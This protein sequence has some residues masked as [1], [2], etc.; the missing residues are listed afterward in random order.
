MDYGWAQEY[1]D[2]REKVRA[3]VDEHDSPEIHLEY[4]QED[5][6]GPR[7]AA[8]R[9]ALDGRGWLRM[10]WP[11]EYGGEGK[12]P[13]YQFILIE[14]L[15]YRAM[16]YGLLSVTSV[17]PAIMAYGSDEQKKR[18]MPGIWDGSVSFAIGYTEPEAGTDLASLQ[19]RAV[20]DGDDWVIN[21]QKIFTSGAHSATH[22][23]LAARTD[24]DAPKHRGIS[25]FIVPIDAPGVTITPM[26]T[27][28]GL[29]T[30]QTFYDDVRVSS[31]ALVGEENRGWYIVAHALNHERVGLAPTG[32]LGRSFDALVQ[33]LRE[34]RPEALEDPQVRMRLAEMRMEVHV[35][36]ALATTNGSIIANGGTPTME[37][38]MAKVW[39]SELRHRLH[40]LAMDLLGRY[41][42]LTRESGDLAP[43]NGRLEM[44]Y[45]TSPI[46]R[47][48]GG[49]NEIQR[50]IIAQRGLGLPR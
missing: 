39:S 9:K 44:I 20:R 17:A 23:W 49:T 38:S 48:G 32:G 4:S 18:Y 34:R 24:S 29:R 8:F 43:A 25:M 42:G 5:R 22:V 15:E 13:W 50:S 21:G 28:S 3:L 12:S 6:R 26:Y 14:E 36:R 35:Q 2:F 45:R 30:N 19:T 31:D 1:V 11:V 33:Y 7:T 16:P 40:S 10:C 41:G 46:L 37:A 47:F 27:M